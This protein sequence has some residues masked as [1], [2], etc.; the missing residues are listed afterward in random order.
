MLHWFLHGPKS[1][2]GNC[3][4]LSHCHNCGISPYLNSEYLKSFCLRNT[5]LRHET[6]EPLTRSQYRN[7]GN[8]IFMKVERELPLSPSYNLFP[9]KSWQFYLRHKAFFS[10]KPLD[11]LVN[12][13]MLHKRFWNW[14]RRKQETLTVTY[15][16]ENM[17]KWCHYEKYNIC[18]Q[19][20]LK[21]ECQLQQ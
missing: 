13:C 20:K 1:R 18:S 2:D 15:M 21:F 5:H 9:A 19:K 16:A 12:N 17:G 3:H 11:L 4:P 7:T 14:R 6:L 10:F 8:N